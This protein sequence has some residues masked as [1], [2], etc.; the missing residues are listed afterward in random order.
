MPAAQA[1]KLFSDRL[2]DYEKGEILDYQ[3]IYYMGKDL[4][5]LVL[6]KLTEHSGYDDDKGDYRVRMGEHLGYRYEIVGLLGKGSFGQALK[7]F[8]HKTRQVVAVK[9]IRS[10]KRFYRQALVEVKVLK[11]IKEHDTNSTSNIVKML[12]YFKFR[13]HIVSSC[14][15]TTSRVVH[16]L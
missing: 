16:R 11:Y 3:E 13:K 10:Q 6:E 15:F 2:G 7:C 9:I 8:D 1:L 5:S 12:E 14:H 4:R